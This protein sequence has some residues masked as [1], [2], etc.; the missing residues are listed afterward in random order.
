MQ[1]NSISGG[2]QA[3]PSGQ[4]SHSATR[5]ENSIGVDIRIGIHNFSKNED[6]IWAEYPL[7]LCLGIHIWSSYLVFI[8]GIH[9]WY[10]YLTGKGRQ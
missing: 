9:I 1:V 3:R 5:R 8:I 7:G 2:K 10:S 4:T 6:Q